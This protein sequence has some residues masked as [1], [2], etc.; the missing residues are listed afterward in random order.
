M[1]LLDMGA[2]HI[3][4]CR[5]RQAKKDLPHRAACPCTD[6]RQAS[7]SIPDAG[8]AQDL[9]CPFAELPALGPAS[10]KGVQIQWMQACGTG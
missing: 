1:C 5:T 4:L 8:S 3:V 10:R 2:L 6:L 9:A 7:L